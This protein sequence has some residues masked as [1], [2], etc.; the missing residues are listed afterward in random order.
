VSTDK[1]PATNTASKQANSLKG[2]FFIGQVFFFLFFTPVSFVK[3]SCLSSNIIKQRWISW[4]VASAVL[5]VFSI[6]PS[7][8]VTLVPLTGISKVAAGVETETNGYT[9]V[10]TTSGGV[11]CWD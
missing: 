2:L 11:K 10:L 1:V 6:Q 9:C 3:K 4:F 7:Y 8:A 5:C